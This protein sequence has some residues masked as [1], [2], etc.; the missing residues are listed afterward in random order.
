[1]YVCI[2]I[3]FL[4]QLFLSDHKFILFQFFTRLLPRIFHHE[5]FHYSIFHIISYTFS[6]LR[7]LFPFVCAYIFNLTLILLH[8]FR[9]NLFLFSVEIEVREEERDDFVVVTNI[10]GKN[11]Q[12]KFRCGK[13]TAR[14]VVV[15]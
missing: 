9:N 6:F 15:V 11:G 12:V 4:L 7:N 14:A 13:L 1:M 10:D 3:V 2:R 8:C 5:Q